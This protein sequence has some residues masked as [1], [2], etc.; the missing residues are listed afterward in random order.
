MLN[1]GLASNNYNATRPPDPNSNRMK[2]R[3]TLECPCFNSVTG[4]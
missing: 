4:P 3:R 2:N 1:G